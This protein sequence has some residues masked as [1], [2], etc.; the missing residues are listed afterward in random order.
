MLLRDGFGAV[1]SLAAAL[2][3]FLDGLFLFFL[4]IFAAAVRQHCCT[5]LLRTFAAAEVRSGL[6]LCHQLFGINLA[7]RFGP[8]RLVF[9][10]VSPGDG[11]NRAGPVLG[12]IGGGTVRRVPR[13]SQSQRKSGRHE[14]GTGVGAAKYSFAN[15]FALFDPFGA[16]PLVVGGSTCEEHLQSKSQSSL[17]LRQYRGSPSDAADAPKPPPSPPRTPPRRRS[18]RQGTEATAE[19]PKPLGRE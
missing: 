11:S 5:A 16:E 18:R 19:A 6:P 8:S 1:A 15:A 7:T 14:A 12:A 13:F 4:A 3:P 9:F 2:V 17:Q 10:L